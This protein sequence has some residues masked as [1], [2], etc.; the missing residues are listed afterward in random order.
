MDDV[1]VAVEAGGE[2]LLVGLRLADGDEAVGPLGGDFACVELV[3]QA[4]VDNVLGQ[5]DRGE[6]AAR[7]VDAGDAGDQPESAGEVEA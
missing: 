1:V 6:R 3:G 5:D 2:R 4:A 7:R